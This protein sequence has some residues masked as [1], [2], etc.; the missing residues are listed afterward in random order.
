MDAMSF[1]ELASLHRLDHGFDEFALG[2]GEGVLVVELAV[3]F[4]NWAQPVDVEG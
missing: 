3:D 4:G 1:A 2:G